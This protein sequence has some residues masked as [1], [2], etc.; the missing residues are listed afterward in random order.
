MN[1]DFFSQCL[2][3]A[4]QAAERG[5]VPI[6]AVIVKDGKVIASS[7][8]QTESEMSFT[9]HA[10]MLCLK[11]ASQV[12]QTKYLEGCELYISLEPCLMCVTAARL[13]RIDAIHYLIASEKFGAQGPGYRDIKLELHDL[14]ESEESRRLLRRFFEARR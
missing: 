12:L 2:Q 13:S 5:E 10:E 1:N 3:L 8:N 11:Q 6:G 7:A 9:A 4:E 14:K